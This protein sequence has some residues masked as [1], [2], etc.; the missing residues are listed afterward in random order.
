MQ[1]IRSI[2]ARAALVALALCSTMDFA[3]GPGG[4]STQAIAEPAESAAAKLETLTGTVHEL[5]VDDSTTGTSQRYVELEL[6]DGSLIALQG[7]A[8]Q[9]LP[10]D[11]T[12]EVRG[13]RSAKALDVEAS[14]ALSRTS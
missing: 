5:T 9:S 12:V 13:R 8:A 7:D 4:S 2:A 14:R 1:L 6:A 3:H 10:R 11:A